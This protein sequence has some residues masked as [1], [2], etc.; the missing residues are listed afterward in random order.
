M[1]WCRQFRLDFHADFATLPAMDLFSGPPPQPAGKETHALSVTQLLRRMKQLLEVKIGEVWVEGE[2]S[3][4]RRQA[5]GHWYFSLKDE[6]AQISCAMFGARSKPGSQAL[7]EGAKVRVFAEATLYEARGQL[8]IIVLRVEPAGAGDLQAR[9][10]ALKRRLHSEGWFDPARKRPLPGFPRVIGLV[11]SPT[12]AAL[13]DLLN[14]LSRRAPWLT[15]VLA[16]V[17]VQGKGAETEIAAAIEQ[18]GH[19]AYDGPP[20]DLLIV[21]RGG[22]SI[23]DLWCFNEEC[24]ARAIVS[25]P[26]PVV[27]AVGHEIDFTIADFAADV[28]A[29]TPSA[30]A[31]ITTPDRAELQAGLQQL[32]ARMHRCAANQCTA[33]ARQLEQFRR[34][35]LARDPERLLREPVQQLDLLRQ[36]LTGTSDAV[37]DRHQHRLEALRTRLQSHHPQRVME[38]R[39]DRIASARS[40][41]SAALASSLTQRGHD[42]QRLRA[43]LRLLGPGSAF[44]RGFS[45]SLGPDGRAVTSIDQLQPGEPLRT[46]VADGEI[47]SRVESASGS[48]TA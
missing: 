9:F 13:Q 8:Q 42:L 21:G 23:E 47:L 33:A 30:A 43:S 37:L 27:S 22:G 1:S 41:F 5:S 35:P 15:V 34:S 44:A 48:V 38:R 19:H 20:C 26:L 14:V 7:T 40:R 3:N 2:V 10:E 45:I 16:P 4:L 29:P 36:R 25:C 24:V 32:A 31:E 6:T 46:R 12:G 28:R 11:T 17:R 18:L 39:S